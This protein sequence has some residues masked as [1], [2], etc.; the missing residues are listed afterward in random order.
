MK[1]IEAKQA[2]ALDPNF[3]SCKIN[4]HFYSFENHFTFSAFPPFR[5]SAEF[6]TLVKFVNFFG[7]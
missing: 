4:L 2:S 1:K 5:F 7:G 6:C 3:V